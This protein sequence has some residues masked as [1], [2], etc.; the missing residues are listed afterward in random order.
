MD[1]TANNPKSAGYKI[2]ADYCIILC[3]CISLIIIAFI[4]D[5]P[6]QIANGFHK[7]NTSRSVL[8]TDYIALG[9]L[10]AALINA[11]VCGLFY[12]I[13][14]IAYKVEPSGKIIL[15][16]FLTIG[17]SLFGKN[18]CNT[19][20]LFF[21][22]LL[23]SKAA[24]IKFSDL[25]VPAM[26]CGTV[27]P[28]ISEIAFLNDS[29]SLYKIF[30]AFAVGLFVGFI[31]PVVMEAAKRM[32]RGYCLYNGGTAGGLIAT[33]FVGILHSVG[34]EILPENYWDSSHTLLLASFS[35]ILAVSLIVFGIIA[36]RPGEAL[37]KFLQL[38]N[39]KDITDNDYLIKY[40]NTC[41]INI[42]IMLIVSTSL[43]LFLGIPINGP[44]LGGILTVAGFAASGKHLKSTAPVFIGSILAAH[45]NH[46]ELNTSVNSLAILFS[47]GL[48]PICAKHGW[49]WGIIV[50]FIHVSVAIIIGNLN[51]G[52][53]LYNNGFAGSFVAITILPIIVFIRELWSSFRGKKDSE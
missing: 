6:D 12:L 45:F 40:G 5:T 4:T 21:G 47:T 37:K 35:Y 11:V 42:G 17:F 34:I 52:L 41:Y 48:A 16:L 44:V 38:Q 22:V 14:L 26:L 2:P 13:L 9:G 39:E 18:I 32:H 36:E 29:T 31:F 25:L 46:L 20:P 51:G 8:V 49:Q 3:I 43:M 15:S 33:F 28:L 27:T 7:I 50:G 23:Y 53:N 10:G 19:L 30:A 1:N 24:R